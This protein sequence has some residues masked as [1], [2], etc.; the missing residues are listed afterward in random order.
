MSWQVLRI[1]IE[2]RYSGHAIYSRR[3]VFNVSF[4][5]AIVRLCH[6]AAS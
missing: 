4:M 3:Y 1:Q 2:G 6:I 5:G